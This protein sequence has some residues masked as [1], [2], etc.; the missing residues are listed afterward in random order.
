MKEQTKKP[1]NGSIRWLVYAVIVTALAGAATLAQY[2]SSVTGTG[3][4]TIG[5]MRMGTQGEAT[6]TAAGIKKPGDESEL[7]FKVVNFEGTTTKTVSDANQD[8]TITLTTT[9]NLPLT[10]TLEC[11]NVNGDTA[12]R[13]INYLSAAAITRGQTASG[14]Y[15]SCAA[16]ATHDYTLKVTWPAGENAPA[17]ADEIERIRITVNSVQAT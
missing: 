15:L 11:T 3:T 2:T 6:F 9:G 13:A 4:A 17:L 7:K 8:Y 16:A 1:R 5:V 14:G 10:Y 12:G